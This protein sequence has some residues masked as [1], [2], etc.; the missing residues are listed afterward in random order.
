MPELLYVTWSQPWES[1]IMWFHPNPKIL[2]NPQSDQGTGCEGAVAA[3]YN[4]DK[5]V[6][7]V[8]C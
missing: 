1:N 4:A 6:V 2:P 5:Q 7:E 8:G 3:V